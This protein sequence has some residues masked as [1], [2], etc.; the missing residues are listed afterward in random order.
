MPRVT[1]TKTTSPGKTA[2]PPEAQTAG[3]AL[4]MAQAD[5]ATGNQYVTTGKELVVAR[6]TTTTARTITITSAADA[7]G[8]LGTITAHALAGSAMNIYGPFPDHGWRQSDGM[9]Y[10][11]ASATTVEIGVIVLP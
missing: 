4:V 8:R 7:I 6:N 3:I 10:V 11:D 5:T 1:L 2:S 9:V